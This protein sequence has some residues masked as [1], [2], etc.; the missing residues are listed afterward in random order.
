M[1]ET[2]PIVFIISSIVLI[3]TPGQDMILVMSRSISQ[4]WKAG[5]ATAAGV[6]VG[7]VGHTVLAS[8]GLGALLSASEALFTVMK[9]LGAVYLFYLGVKILRDRHSKMNLS[10]LPETPL[11]RAFF[12]G[13]L[14][15]LS[16][17]KIAIFYFAY[18][19]QFAPP[20]AENPTGHLFLLGAAFAA[21]TF[22]IKGPVGYGAGVLSGWLRSRP[23]VIKGINRVSGVVLIGLGLRLAFESRN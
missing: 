2:F 12:Q 16:N 5:V 3:I 21:L 1:L 19:P 4:G 20:G 18:L 9:I 8:F 23:A 17:P 13:A 10:G 14:S 11:P 6:S 22:L 7:L 15:N